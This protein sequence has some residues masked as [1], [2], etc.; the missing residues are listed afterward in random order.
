VEKDTADSALADARRGK[1][2][3]TPFALLGS[4]ALLIAVVAGL[5][6]LALL[7]IYLL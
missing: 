7:L 2:P 4:T 1:A 3:W 6:T 5:V